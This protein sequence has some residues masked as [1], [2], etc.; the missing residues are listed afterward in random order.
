MNIAG[1]LAEKEC[2][3]PGTF[4]AKFIDNLYLIN[5]DIIRKY[6]DIEVLNA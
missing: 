4:R 2:N 3:L 5:S 1:E 6:A